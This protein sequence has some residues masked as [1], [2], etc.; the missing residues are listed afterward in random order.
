MVFP[1]VHP[2]GVLRHAAAD[3]FTERL[4]FSKAPPVRAWEQLQSILGRKRH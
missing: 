3:A 1:L 4:I 2:T